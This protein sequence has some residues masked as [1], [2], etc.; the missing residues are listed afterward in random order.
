ML[1]YEDRME[2]NMRNVLN[3]PED[4]IKKILEM[5]VEEAL[6]FALLAFLNYDEKTDTYSKETDYDKVV[7]RGYYTDID[8]W[9]VVFNG[10]YL[11]E[12]SIYHSK[13]EPLNTTFQLSISV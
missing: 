9:N 11:C 7:D 10:Y 13:K 3:L 12:Y 4:L 1:T 8:S 5:N 6:S 2:D